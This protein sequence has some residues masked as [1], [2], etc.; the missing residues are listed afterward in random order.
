MGASCSARFTISFCHACGNRSERES[1]KHLSKE[2]KIAIGLGGEDEDHHCPYCDAGNEELEEQ[3]ILRYPEV[4]TLTVAFVRSENL[5][6]KNGKD[7]FLF[8]VVPKVVERGRFESCLR[9]GYLK[10]KNLVTVT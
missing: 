8:R 6:G 7:S 3:E 10:K 1:T 9:S 5:V 4:Q 2:E